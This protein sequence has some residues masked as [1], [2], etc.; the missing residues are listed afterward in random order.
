MS[1]KKPKKVVYSANIGNP[2][3]GITVT[4]RRKHSMKKGKK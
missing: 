3:H 1:E 4:S 2:Y